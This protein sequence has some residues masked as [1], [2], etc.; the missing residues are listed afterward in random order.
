MV[1][2]DQSS[3]GSTV[4]LAAG[5]QAQLTLAETRSGGY[6]W[7]MISPESPVFST[8]DDGFEMAAGVGGAGVHRWTITAR[9]PGEAKLELVHGRSWEPETGKRFVVTVVVK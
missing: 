2:I 5:E 4:Q 8:K 3:A 6:K 1:Q 9:Q 7:Q